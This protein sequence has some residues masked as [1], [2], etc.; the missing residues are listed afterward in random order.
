MITRKK[1]I[2]CPNC[3]GRGVTTNT[4]I[5]PDVGFT[6]SEWD[7]LDYESQDMYMSGAYDNTCTKCNGR[8]VV[9]VEIHTECVVCE[10]KI[11]AESQDYD[12]TWCSEECWASSYHCGCGS[13]RCGWCA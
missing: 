4:S 6:Q 2:V 11:P 5:Y 12:N 1:I 3:G 7:E 8:N 10:G 13:S 9:E